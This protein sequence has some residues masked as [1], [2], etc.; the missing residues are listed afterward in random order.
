[1]QKKFSV[2]E[3]APEILPL[4]FHSRGITFINYLDK[5]NPLLES[6]LFKKVHQK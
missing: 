1:M 2:Q 4:V 3:S 5:G 6:A